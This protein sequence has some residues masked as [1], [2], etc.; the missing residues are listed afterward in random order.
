MF[1]FDLETGDVVQTLIDHKEREVRDIIFHQQ[2]PLMLT[3]GDDGTVN[4]YKICKNSPKSEELEEQSEEEI[5][6]VDTNGS[7]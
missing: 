6:V 2:R 1:L 5:S 7:S 4:V 3:S